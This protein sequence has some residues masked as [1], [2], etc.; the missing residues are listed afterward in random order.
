MYV[1]ADEEQQKVR[2]QVELEFVQCLAN[3]NY[4][5]CEYTNDILNFLFCIVFLMLRREVSDDVECLAWITKKPIVVGYRFSYLH[6]ITSF[7]Q[8]STVDQGNQD[9]STQIFSELP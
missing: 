1:E 3:P 6:E 9:I 8:R 5:N 4:L 2:F 7:S